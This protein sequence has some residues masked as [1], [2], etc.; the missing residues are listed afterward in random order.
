[1]F[2]WK[3]PG[4]AE[5]ELIVWITDAMMIRKLKEFPY[6]SRKENINKWTAK[7]HPVNINYLHQ[8][9]SDTQV[10]TGY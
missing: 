10:S 5:I 6:A 3:L 2:L 4:A 1:M 7:S 8:R 9:I